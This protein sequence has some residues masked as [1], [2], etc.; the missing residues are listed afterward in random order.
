ME[1]IKLLIVDDDPVWL[2]SMSAFLNKE[3][4]FFVAGIAHT[5]EE[6][7]K[8]VNDFNFDVILMDLN[9]SGDQFDGID[10]SLEILNIK[11]VKIIILTSF[12]EREVIIG[13]FAAGAVN[14]FCKD[15]YQNIP[16]AVRATYNNISPL[17]VLVEE[18]SHLRKETRL[19]IL[20]AAEKE[21]YQLRKAGYSVSQIGSLLQKSPST[22]KK[23]VNHILKKF[24]VG[25]FNDLHL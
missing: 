11:K 21:V 24:R 1:K 5:K 6:A 25:K 20:T 4:D 22:I 17:E 18:Y 23:Q 14:Y 16:D 8:L 2:K 3:E 9:L 7:V 19:N 13:A 15:N 12:Q 10:L